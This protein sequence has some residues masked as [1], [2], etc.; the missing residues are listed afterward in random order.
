MDVEEITCTTN[1]GYKLRIQI[2][3]IVI[4]AI[5]FMTVIASTIY[6]IIVERYECNKIP[7]IFN[8][9]DTL[10]VYLPYRYT[11][12]DANDIFAIYKW[13]ESFHDDRE[14]TRY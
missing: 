6:E 7:I 3:A 2:I 5:L 13:N 12:Y 11:M 9:N 10:I 14:S 8:I 4:F 1:E